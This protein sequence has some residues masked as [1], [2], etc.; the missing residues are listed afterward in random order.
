MNKKEIAGKI[1]DH[2]KKKVKK[3][4][5][6]AIRWL[7]LGS[8]FLLCFGYFLGIHHRVIVAALTGAKLPAPPKGH[9]CH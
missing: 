4:A 9:C 5:K 1:V 8:I 3:K 7:V 6:K 2:E